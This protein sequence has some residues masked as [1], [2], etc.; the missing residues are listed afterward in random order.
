MLAN[1]QQCKC[2]PNPELYKKVNGVRCNLACPHSLMC[3]AHFTITL[4]SVA[5][6]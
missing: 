1:L 4:A 6:A 2:S 5:R 3:I